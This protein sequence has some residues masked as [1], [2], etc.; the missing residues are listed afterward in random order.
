MRSDGME[1]IHRLTVLTDINRVLHETIAKERSIDADLDRLLL[2]RMELERSFL[3][4]NTPTAEVQCC[5][6]F[7]LFCFSAAHMGS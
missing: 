7:D 3:S 1:V 4:L 6:R 2:K 5:V